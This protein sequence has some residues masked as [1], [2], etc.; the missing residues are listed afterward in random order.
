MTSFHGQ[1]RHHQKIAVT[2]SAAV[3]PLQL[4]AVLYADE[5]LVRLYTYAFHLWFSAPVKIEQAHLDAEDN[6]S[7]NIPSRR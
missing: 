2:D 3:S 7:R 5:T 1:W 6:A 4:F